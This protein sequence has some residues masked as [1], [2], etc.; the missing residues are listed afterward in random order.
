[1]LDTLIKRRKTKAEPE[2]LRQKMTE[3]QA[4][5][6]GARTDAARA[7][8]DVESLQGEIAELD[9]LEEIGEVT[10][11]EADKARTKLEAALE[12]ADERKAA[13]EAD[14]RRLQAS[15]RIYGE[16]ITESE[17]EAQK[18]ARKESAQAILEAVD[19]VEKHWQ[20]AGEAALRL[21]ELVKNTRVR[22]PVSLPA[23]VPHDLF[24]LTGTGPSRRIYTTA[25][26]LWKKQ[27]RGALAYFEREIS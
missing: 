15:A 25:A 16:K 4:A 20:K 23:I 27:I 10:K 24:H 21:D 11:G 2:T 6:K 18:K 14:A 17:T 3:T 13:S 26:K 22:V 8:S 5:L 1:M 7:K 9:A 19:E 12:K